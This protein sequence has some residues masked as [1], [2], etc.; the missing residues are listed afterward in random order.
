M[1]RSRTIRLAMLGSASALAL[2]ACDEAKD[3]LAEANFFRDPVECAQKLDRASC[4]ASFA[5]ARSEHLKSAPAF[6]SR[7]S[8]EQAYG[9]ANCSWQETNVSPEQV[10]EQKPGA[11]TPS[12]SSGGGWFMPLMMGY[13]LGNALGNRGGIMPGQAFNPGQPPLTPGQ[14]CGGPGQPSCTTGSTSS[15]SST[16]SSGSSFA[17]RPIYRNASDQVFSGRTAL[18]SSKIAATTASSRGGFGSTSRSYS[19]SSSS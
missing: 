10:Q 3:P 4:E 13:M 16:R 19:S 9:A 17:A 11:G 2:V 1:K 5:E 8:C 12:A 18:G 7:E 15:S 14:T 6:A